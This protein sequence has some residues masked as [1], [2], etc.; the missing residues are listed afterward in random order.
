MTARSW[1]VTE[2]DGEIVDCQLIE[3]GQPSLD[4]TE[5]QR[6]IDSRANPIER[7]ETAGDV[8]IEAARFAIGLLVNLIAEIQKEKTPTITLKQ[9]GYAMLGKQAPPPNWFEKVTLVK[10]Q[11]KLLKNA[12]RSFSCAISTLDND[13]RPNWFKAAR[14]I[15]EDAYDELKGEGYEFEGDESQ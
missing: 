15:L 6:V 1:Q 3:E 7:P 9:I 8:T 13:S 14:S 10:R 4:A 12:A 2:P 11:D 5:S